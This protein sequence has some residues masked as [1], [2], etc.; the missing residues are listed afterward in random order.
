MST[1]RQKEDLGDNKANKLR[2]YGRVVDP[3]EPR[4]ETLKVRWNYSS[5]SEHILSRCKQHVCKHGLRNRKK[6]ANAAA[7]ICSGMLFICVEIIP[8]CCLNLVFKSVC[9]FIYQS[10]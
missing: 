6:K 1:N 7:S 8:D 3:R 4:W 9:V 5:F 2:I 10:K